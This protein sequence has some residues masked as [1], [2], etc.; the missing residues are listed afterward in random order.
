VLKR[1]RYEQDHWD[2]VIINFRECEHSKW[3]AEA[4]AVLEQLRSSISAVASPTTTTSS[5]NTSPTSPSSNPIT[6]L[7]FLPSVHILDLH[8]E[9]YIKPHVDSVK[10]SG[11]IVAGLSLLSDAVMRLRPYDAEVDGPVDESSYADCVLP[12]RS[13]YVMGGAAR[14]QFTHEILPPAK[15]LFDGAEVARGRRIS[16]MLRDV[17]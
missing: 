2:A 16:I 17:L 15:S 7:K 14:Y 12:Q 8:A 13:L 10:F 3:S 9:G 11:G 1:R 6:P 4:A 5:S